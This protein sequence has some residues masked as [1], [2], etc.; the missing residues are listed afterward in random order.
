[1]LK[2]IDIQALPIQ[3]VISTS[4]SIGTYIRIN[5]RFYNRLTPYQNKNWRGC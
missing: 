5:N 1:M 2:G 4:Y 3:Q